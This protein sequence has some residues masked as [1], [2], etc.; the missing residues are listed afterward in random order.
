MLKIRALE[1]DLARSQ[2]ADPEHL[3]R[4]VATFAE[5]GGNLLT[6]NLEHRFEFPSC[7][8]LAPPGSLTAAMARELVEFG[9]ARG[10][11]VV[12]QPNLIGHCEGLG[13]TERYAEL[14]CDPFRQIP[15]GGYEQ[16][17]LEKPEAR[18]LVRRMLADV[19]AAFPG[20]YLHIGGDEVR[21]MDCLFPSDRDRQVARML[22][23]FAFVLGEARRTGRRIMMWGDMPLH[24]DVL[25]RTLPRDVIICDWHYGPAGSR[26]TL[27][28]YRKEGFRVLAAPSTGCHAAFC[29]SPDAAAENIRRMVGDARELEL[30]GFLLTQWEAGFGSGFDLVWPWIAL[31]AETADGKPLRTPEEFLAAFASER[32]GVEGADFARLHMLLRRDFEEAVRLGGAGLPAR[33]GVTLRKALF[34]AADPFPNLARPEGLAPNNHQ[35]VWEPSPFHPWLYLRPIL[36]DAMR[37]RFA[38]IAGEADLLAERLRR[39]ARRRIGELEA[40]LTLARAFG[41]L[42][43]RL[44]ILDEAKA[45]YHA[46]AEAQGRDDARFREGLAATAA[47]LERVRPGL[48]ALR[49]MI[50]RLDAIRGFDPGEIEWLRIHEASLDAHLAVLRVRKAGDDGLIEFGEFLRR[51]AHITPR[52]TWR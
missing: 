16:L 38:E 9:R 40:L 8:G 32:Y 28:R 41:I 3:K 34:R 31:A 36:N 6:L 5:L 14:T 23:Y 45:R 17:N 19:C 47:T 30:E 39:T 44:R 20:E 27:E 37:A 49:E 10:V 26:E 25:M 52:L 24:H 48:R 43:E 35:Q 46:A 51:P 18:D 33:C 4:V 2:R 29:S 13:A 50:E 21:R 15:W 7:P 22:E 1:Y 12:A 42:V 11:T